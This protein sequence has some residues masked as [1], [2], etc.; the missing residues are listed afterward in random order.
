LRPFPALNLILGL[1]QNRRA[2]DAGIIAF[3][4][5]NGEARL[6]PTPEGFEQ[7]QLLDVF[8]PT[9]KVIAR[10]IRSGATGS[11]LLIYDLKTGDLEIVPNPEGIA[12]VGAL[13]AAP[14]TPG[15]PGQP[16]LPGQ[17]GQPG[18]AQTAQLQRVNP[19]ANAVV[20]IGFNAERK[21]V[22]VVYFRIP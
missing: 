21:P 9:R 18:A 14:T 4:L 10:G 6:M 16:G 15:Q 1:G 17:P 7:V 3:D 22:S 20:A 13:P 8:Q 12:F 2:G 19:K 11:Q 5:E